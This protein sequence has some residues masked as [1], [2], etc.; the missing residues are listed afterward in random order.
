MSS[1]EA[2][3]LSPRSASGQVRR[4]SRDADTIAR[5]MT[6]FPDRDQLFE[7][8]HKAIPPIE[9][10][11]EGWGGDAMEERVEGDRSFNT[12]AV[13]D[14]RRIEKLTGPVE[15]KPRV[16]GRATKVGREGEI[17]GYGALDDQE[18]RQ[19]AEV[20]GLAGRQEMTR[21]QLIKALLERE[22]Y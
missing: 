15:H 8:G 1:P 16:E 19:R 13:D 22:Q 10:D 12:D 18:L 2:P 6:H 3:A 7:S 14:L 20:L 4:P 9:E 21:A 17:D 11:N 5:E